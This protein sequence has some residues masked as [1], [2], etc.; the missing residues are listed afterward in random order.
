MAWPP[1]CGSSP[2]AHKLCGRYE[3]WK[4]HQTWPTCLLIQMR[5]PIAFEAFQNVKYP[6]SFHDER[7][8]EKHQNMQ[9]QTTT[10]TQNNILVKSTGNKARL[11]S[12]WT[13]Q[14]AVGEKKAHTHTMESG[15]RTFKVTP[16]HCITNSRAMNVWKWQKPM[17]TD[18]ERCNSAMSDT[19]T[20]GLI[21][22]VKFVSISL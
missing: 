20:K 12:L 4:K 3:A 5:W 13:Q 6:L 7:D 15:K 22:N 16:P 2:N 21:K 19:H 14:K 9:A 8:S 10:P 17:Q 1:D 18:A 11:C